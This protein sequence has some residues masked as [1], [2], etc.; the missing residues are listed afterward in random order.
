[1]TSNAF[2]NPFSV[3]G[4]IVLDPPSNNLVPWAKT[5]ITTP[6]V[7]SVTSGP[8]T[9]N[10]NI[11][12]QGSR[13]TTLAEIFG[14]NFSSAIPQ[15]FIAFPAEGVNIDSSVFD[16]SVTEASTI[17]SFTVSSSIKSSF[18]KLY[19]T[20]EALE[21][22][23]DPILT[24]D[25]LMTLNSSNIFS[26]F[27]SIISKNALLNHMVVYRYSNS[28]PLTSSDNWNVLVPA[29]NSWLS[30]TQPNNNTIP[31]WFKMNEVFDIGF[32][33]SFSKG[34]FAANTMFPTTISTSK[35]YGVA[36]LY[37]NNNV[38]LSKITDGVISVPQLYSTPAVWNMVLTDDFINN[39]SYLYSRD[40][41]NALTL[42]VL[43][44]SEPGGTPTFTR[45]ESIPE[46]AESYAYNFGYASLPNEAPLLAYCFNSS[47][48]LRVRLRWSDGGNLNT[49]LDASTA[50]NASPTYASPLIYKYSSTLYVVVVVSPASQN[51]FT[52]NVTVSGGFPTDITLAGTISNFTTGLPA[53]YNNLSTT[54]IGSYIDDTSAHPYLHICFGGVDN[55][56]TNR[57]GAF[58][59][60]PF[61]SGVLQNTRVEWN[62]SSGISNGDA[63]GRVND[64]S[65]GYINFVIRDN[66]LY[67]GSGPAFKIMI[68]GLT[69][70][71]S[72]VTVGLMRT[73]D[74][75]P[76]PASTSTN[77]SALVV[78]RDGNLI[79]T[80]ANATNTSQAGLSS[81]ASAGSEIYFELG[82]VPNGWPVILGQV[83]ASVQATSLTF[84]STAGQMISGTG[85]IDTPISLSALDLGIVTLRPSDNLPGEKIQWMNVAYG[86]TA[87]HYLKGTIRN[88]A[89]TSN[90]AMIYS[91]EDMQYG[92]SSVDYDFNDIMFLISGEQQI[93]PGGLNSSN[94]LLIQT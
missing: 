60:Y 87:A 18:G 9:V 91:F 40:N 30:D 77:Y 24:D 45:V 70:T 73:I 32:S 88:V 36:T 25:T 29:L 94:A 59:S 75:K 92:T 90:I 5:D 62:I 28:T 52:F 55:G 54:N 50:A 83:G 11:P 21:L 74:F 1:M 8:T 17:P 13:T 23:E 93:A 79:V 44:Y 80:S 89:S 2:L 43:D 56:G 12:Y 22:F 68:A 49:T 46:T 26:P 39:R 6:S 35:N 71:S 20:T 16:A 3:K 61:V 67:L 31:L 15:N 58:V 37:N 78:S 10:W 4:T 7:I 66:T 41:G 86:T 57:G 64:S 19:P 63:Y 51:I 82:V 33:G 72:S 47:S 42:Q 85:T 81:I 27:L 34:A 38:L 84:N 48:E 76:D 14:G 65:L 69:I 53:V